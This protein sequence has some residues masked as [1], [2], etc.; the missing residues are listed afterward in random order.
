[1]KKYSKVTIHGKQYYKVQ[2]TGADG[3]RVT[4]YARTVSA[5]RT[6]EAAFRTVHQQPGCTHSS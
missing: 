1:M 2:P 6:K 4:L 3:K 5:L